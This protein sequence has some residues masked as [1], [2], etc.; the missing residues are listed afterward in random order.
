[1]LPPDQPNA[2]LSVSMDQEETQQDTQEATQQTSQEESQEDHRKRYWGYLNPC[3]SRKARAYLDR[4]NP[5]YT[6]G[7]SLSSNIVLKGQKVS[8]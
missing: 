5:H 1:M 8:E 7:R 3:S 4:M 2:D 6:I